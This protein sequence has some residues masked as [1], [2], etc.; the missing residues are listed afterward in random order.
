MSNFGI[1]NQGSCDPEADQLN[2]LVILDQIKDTDSR[3][4]TFVFCW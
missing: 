4:Q 1:P 3:E 2:Q